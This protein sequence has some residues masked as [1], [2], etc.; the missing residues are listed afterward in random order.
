MDRRSGKAPMDLSTC[1]A[2]SFDCYGTLIDWESGI[3][4]ALQPWLA[5]NRLDLDREDLLA[6]FG[7]VETGVE[8]AQPTLPYPQVLAESLRRMAANLRVDTTDAE[9]AAFGAS[10]PDWPAF[11]DTAAA[12]RRLKERFKLFILSNVD[13]ASF[14]ESSK[15][16]GVAFDLVITAEDVGSYKPDQRNFDRLF[17]DLPAIGVQKSELVHVAESLFHDHGPAQANA[18]PSVWIHRRRGKTGSGATATP[19][20]VREPEWTYPSMAAFADAALA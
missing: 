16:L 5:R 2:L 14:A 17:A 7:K 9:C 12:L 15:K 4:A 6:E 11:S 20:A 1:K 3:V 8:A 18:L 13:R 19:M 10:V